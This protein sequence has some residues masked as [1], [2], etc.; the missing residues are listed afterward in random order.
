MCS[1]CW[2]FS[3][4][5]D[6]VREHFGRKYPVGLLLGGLR[7]G[8][9]EGMSEALKA[10]IKGHWQHVHLATGQPFDLAFY[11]RKGYIYDTEPACRA[12][13]AVR[14]QEPERVFEYLKKVQEGFYALNRD[15]TAPEVLADIA[16]ESGLDRGSFALRFQAEET[17]R[18]T[19][20]D[21][22]TSRR[23]G[24]AGFPCLL[25]ANEER[26]TEVITAGYRPWEEVRRTIEDF[27]AR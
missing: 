13:V 16:A 24:V 6:A 21:F 23:L 26:D 27:A 4:V 5:L 12:V 20:R 15:V 3:P 10:D 2:G 17:V 7:P 18:E 14:R 19:W 1:W 8:T 11:D 22:E 9:T 25:A